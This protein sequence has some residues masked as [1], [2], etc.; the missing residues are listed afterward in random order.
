MRQLRPDAQEIPE[1]SVK[2]QYKYMKQQEE[3]QI[4]LIQPFTTFHQGKPVQIPYV[5]SGLLVQGG[6]SVIGAKQ[7]QG[8]SSLARYEA[9]CV[10]KG[11]PFLGR[12]TTR[13]EVILISLEDPR[14]QV[15]NHLSALGYDQQTDEKIHIVDSLSP[16]MDVTIQAL[17][18][19]LAGMPNVR[20][21]IVDTLMKLLRIDDVNSYM[22]VLKGVEKL[23][24]LARRFPHLHIQGICHCKKIQTT[25]PFDSLLG[26]TSLRGE[27][28]AGI[29]LFQ[30]SGQR[31]IATETRVGRNIPATI[32]SAH[33]VDCGGADFVS[34]FSLDADFEQ[35]KAAQSG[36][37][38]KKRK[39]DYK[40][41]IVAY[42]S[43][44]EHDAA[45]QKILLEE[46]EGKT[47][48]LLQ[49]IQELAADKVL[50]IRGTKHSAA[51][52]LT[53]KLE[54]NALKA[55]DF[56]NQFGGKDFQ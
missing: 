52:P 34:S 50:T 16:N 5:I 3:F 39:L 27:V 32:I 44:R 49:A 21:I 36:K 2:A 9:L 40:E 55:F 29:A 54:R 23:R 48:K 22:D 14:H 33:M 25:D 20:L 13:G 37:S 42:L 4:Q 19:T 46:V 12:E 35:W 18:K 28:D 15:D 24:N 8:K 17:E 53:I 45:V 47:E 26:S 30:D 51:D 10:A 11:Q 41:R 6:F 7:K 56:I 31:V 38:K 43:G 1:T